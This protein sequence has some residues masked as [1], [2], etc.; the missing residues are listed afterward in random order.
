MSR[1]TMTVLI[2]S[3]RRPL[4]LRRCLSH[5]VPQLAEGDELIVVHRTDDGETAAAARDVWGATVLVPVTEP[6]VWA[7]LDVGVRAA[8]GDVVAFLDDDAIPMYGWVDAVRRV[9]EDDP[10]VGAAGGPILNFLGVRTSNA[11]FDGGFITRTTRAGRLH[12]RLHE[13]PA[14]RR[15]EEVDFLQGSNMAIRRELINLDRYPMIGMAP[16][17]EWR[18]ALVVRGR[19]FRILYDS[20]IRVEHHPAPRELSRADRERVARDVGYSM[21]AVIGAE[22]HGAQRIGPL[23]WWALV[24]SRESPGL[25]FAAAAALRG[26]GS[27]RKWRAGTRGRVQGIAAACRARVEA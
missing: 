23:A 14:H 11:F 19:G 24:G 6:G 17:F 13:L 1:T 10:S 20:D 9:L 5:L 22:L 27:L 8:R 3:H 18:V 16:A 15:V 12:S 25:L 4:D 2:P 7:A 21:L 26:R